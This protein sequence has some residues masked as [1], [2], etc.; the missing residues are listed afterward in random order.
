VI[1]QGHRGVSLTLAVAGAMLSTLYLA[2]PTSAACSSVIFDFAPGLHA[3]SCDHWSGSE[4]TWTVPGNITK[5][6]FGV[7]GADDAVGGRGGFIRAKLPVEAGETLDLRMGGDGAASA[8]SRGGESL[9]VAGGG[10][11]I[12]PNSISPE[13]EPLEVEAPGQPVGPGIGDGSVFIEWY[14]AREPFDLVDPLPYVVIDIFDSRKVGFAYVG[15]WQEWVVPEGVD[16]ALFELWGGAGE[17]GEPR[18]HV[19]AG[20]EVSPGET[21]DIR[22]GGPGADTTLHAGLFSVGVAAG[23]DTER[24]NYFPWMSSP[25]EEF[26]EGGGIGSEPGDGHAIVHYWPLGGSTQNHEQLSVDYSQDPAPVCIV[27]RL[28]NRTPRVARDALVRAHCAPG[29]V[30]RRSARKQMRGLVVSQKPHAGTVASV[31]R[32]VAVVIGTP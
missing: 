9:L 21:F 1:R 8:V 31:D 29:K 26:W 16:R 27:P 23:G 15:G 2:S 30:T 5:P 32:E 12:E 28:R 20:L 17:S 3:V 6:E 11:G 7:R 4:E 13:A 24:P 25:E 18:G 19:L 14:D 22:V 10:D